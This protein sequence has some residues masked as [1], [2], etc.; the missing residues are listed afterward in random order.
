VVELD[1]QDAYQLLVAT[2]LSAQSTD[3]M[4]NTITPALFA[5]YPDARALA[6]ADPAEVEP[7][8]FKS[9]F[10]RNKARSIVGMAR[11]VHQD[12]AAVAHP[13]RRGAQDRKKGR[14]A[15]AGGDEPPAPAGG[16]SARTRNPEGL[17]AT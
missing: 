7:L 15:G 8:I 10:Y 9:G 1:H 11:A 12:H 4:I 13:G 2:I 6:K 5:K 17:S 3:K 16:T 14:D